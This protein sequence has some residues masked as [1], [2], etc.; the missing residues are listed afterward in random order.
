[1]TFPLPIECPVPHLFRTYSTNKETQS[2]GVKKEVGSF[3]LCFFVGGI[4]AE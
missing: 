4:G 2:N 1:M 3:A